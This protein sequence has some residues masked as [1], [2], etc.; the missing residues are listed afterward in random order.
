MLCNQFLARVGVA[1]MTRGRRGQLRAI[2][3]GLDFGR[4]R[5]GE[6]DD[7]PISIRFF[8]ARHRGPLN[9]SGQVVH[10]QLLDLLHETAFTNGAL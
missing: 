10:G 7:G 9:F 4:R 6:E 5:P 1:R 3:T 8:P 2:W